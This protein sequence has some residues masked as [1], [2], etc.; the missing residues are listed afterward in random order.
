MTDGCSLWLPP[1]ACKNTRAK[2]QMQGSM[3]PYW[4]MTPKPDQHSG[5]RGTVYYVT[6][7]DARR[8]AREQQVPK[9]RW[10][11]TSVVWRVF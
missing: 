2:A 1:T 7:R 9:N 11:A 3:W 8:Q 10:R 5:E 6:N 4:T